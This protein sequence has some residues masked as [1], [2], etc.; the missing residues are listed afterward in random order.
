VFANASQVDEDG[1]ALGDACDAC[2]LDA[3]NDADHDGVCGNVDNCP[4]IA[5]AGQSNVDGD[6]LGDACD[7]CPLD[8]ANDSDGDGVCGNVDNCPAIANSIQ[9]NADGDALG[10]ACDACPL[11]AAN[12][13]DGDGLCGN[14]D[15]C[16]TVANANQ[17]DGDADSLGD[18]CDNCRKVANPGQ[19]DANGNG[20]GDACVAARDS[21]W[22]T[23]LTHTV[24]TGNDRLLMFVVGHEDNQDVLVNA[25][26]YGGQSLTRVNG[27]LA[28]TTSRVRIE[29]WYLNE[30]G[31]AAAT[32]GT[33]VVTYNGKNPSSPH[34][35]AATFR[36]VD[37]TTPILASS[38]NSTNASTPNPL[39]TS[40]SVTSDGM[41][42]AAAISGNSGSFT[43]GNGWT[44]GTNQS[45]S[46]SNS[47]S[48]DHSATAA[49]T[50]T[51]SATHTNQN[52]QAIVAASLSVAR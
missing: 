9:A 42:I 52:R 29:L 33:F 32:N 4:A 41:A 27:T 36:N 50:D 1:D 30:T 16:P 10:D 3:A 20:V 28:G 49:G 26:T 44:E 21:A 51:A 12:D 23:G 11:D 47:S 2:P 35:A 38:V 25:V 6:A 8:A 15:N 37:Q 43:W 40:V 34:F 22:T 19:Q 39:P 48:A 45:V 14:V 17:A 5:N 24:G 7:A 13:V 31:I 18:A 46:T